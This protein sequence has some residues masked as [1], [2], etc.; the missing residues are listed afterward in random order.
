MERHK[1]AHF[2][3]IKENGNNNKQISI[4]A[5]ANLAEIALT[6]DILEF[7]EKTFKQKCGTT[8]GTKFVPPYAI[9]FIADLEGKILETFETKPIDLVEIHI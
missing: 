4:D 9:P 6:N 7:N 8:I 2:S 1:Q 3:S 5:S